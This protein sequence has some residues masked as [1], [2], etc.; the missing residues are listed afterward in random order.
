MGINPQTNATENL[1][2]IPQVALNKTSAALPIPLRRL[3]QRWM[4]SGQTIIT[5]SAGT[6]GSK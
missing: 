6:S 5:A 1:S 4:R 3:S 2:A